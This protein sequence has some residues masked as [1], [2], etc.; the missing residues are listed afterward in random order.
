M[1]AACY[2]RPA[3]PLHTFRRVPEPADFA[4]VGAAPRR[5]VLPPL[6]VPAE[7]ECH[8]TPPD[9]AERMAARLPDMTGRDVLEP[10]AGTGNLLR[11]LARVHP[12]ARVQAVEVYRPLWQR[13]NDAG[14]VVAWSDFEEWAASTPQRFD[15]VVMNPP[16]RKVRAHVAAARRLLRPGGILV[17]LVPVTF[18]D[19]GGIERLPPDTFAAARVH[20]KIVQIQG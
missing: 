5:P 15:A 7:L 11:A 4:E 12:G 1:K 16:F 14:Y 9:V 2:R 10:S 18:V 17:A 19:G 20:T 13:L 8:V 3:K 6:A